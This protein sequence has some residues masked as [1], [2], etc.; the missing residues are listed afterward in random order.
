MKET[1]IDPIG[2]DCYNNLHYVDYEVMNIPRQTEY[3]LKSAE[4]DFEV[5][6][7]LIEAD[8]PRQGLLL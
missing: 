7:N 4:E 1:A 5:G 8:K 3:W 6:R 2:Q